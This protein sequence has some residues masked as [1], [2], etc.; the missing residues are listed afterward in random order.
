MRGV[1]EVWED[2]LTDLFLDV[3][4]EALRVFPMP[5]EAVGGVVEVWGAVAAVKCSE[6]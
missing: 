4:Q 1:V 2:A 3:G 6:C 5:V